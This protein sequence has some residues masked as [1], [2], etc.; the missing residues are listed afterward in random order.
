[1]GAKRLEVLRE[2]VPTAKIIGLLTNPNNQNI[3][4][5]VPDLHAT[6]ASLGL[7]LVVGFASGESDVVVAFDS[8]VQSQVQALLVDPDA[9]FFSHRQLITALAAR[10]SIPTVYVSRLYVEGGGLMSYG[11][12][13][14]DAY[15]EVGSY[16]G[17]ILKGT[18]DPSLSGG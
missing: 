12:D 7:Q 5:V 4:T 18:H 16:A 10:H 15:R 9:V 14:A 11:A 3:E 8:L 13:I 1:M 17:K 2:L 6:A